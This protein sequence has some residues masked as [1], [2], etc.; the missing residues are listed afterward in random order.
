MC[1]CVCVSVHLCVCVCMRAHARVCV[2]LAR[3]L[4]RSPSLGLSLGPSP[5]LTLSHARALVDEEA[6]VY[7]SLRQRL[8][9]LINTFQ[10]NGKR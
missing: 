2:S 4:A 6:S 10:K 7:S 9:S 1:L 8:T 3:A 5:G